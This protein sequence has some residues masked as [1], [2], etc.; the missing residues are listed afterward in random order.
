MRV[1]RCL[2]S[3][4]LGGTYARAQACAH[5]CIY[6]HETPVHANDGQRE[7]MMVDFVT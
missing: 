6:K 3:F 2:Y 5:T 1:R 7:K 4:G